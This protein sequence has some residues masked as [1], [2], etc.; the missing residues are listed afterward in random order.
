MS[1]TPPGNS[2]LPDFLLSQIRFRVRTL[3]RVSLKRAWLSVECGDWPHPLER[4]DQSEDCPWDQELAS[5]VDKLDAALPDLAIDDETLRGFESGNWLVGSEFQM[6]APRKILRGFVLP[7]RQ[8]AMRVPVSLKVF[9]FITIDDD[10]LLDRHL[11]QGIHYHYCLADKRH[12][13]TM[14]CWDTRWT[15]DPGKPNEVRAIFHEL[16]A[17]G[18]KSV[19]ARPERWSDEKRKSIRE[20]CAPDLQRYRIEEFR[21]ASNDSSPVWPK[22]ATLTPRLLA[23]LKTTLRRKLR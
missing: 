20:T 23:S 14:V 5:L 22:T 17:E 8:V 11:F 10:S 9:A 2:S 13:T 16:H 1:D 19:R 15:P 21:C 4:M 7:V 6:L 18:A 3:R 12:T